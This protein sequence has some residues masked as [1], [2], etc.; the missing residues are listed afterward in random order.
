MLASLDLPETWTEHLATQPIPLRTP[1]TFR[2]V[3]GATYG[4]EGVLGASTVMWSGDV[5]G[6][7]PLNCTHVW[8]Y[9]QAGAALFPGLEASM[10]ATEFD[11]MLSPD[12]VLPHRVFMPPYLRQ[13]WDEP[14]GG[15]EE[16]AL[17][18][19]CGAVLKIYRELL[20]GA[21]DLSWVEARWDR[22]ASLMDHIARTWDPDDT[23]L[24]QGIQPTTHDI[25]LH[26]ANPFTGTYWLAALRAAEELA[27]L[28][29]DDA[30]A[31][32]WRARFERS[33]AGLDAECFRDGHYVQVPEP[34]RSRV[35]QR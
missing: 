13:L 14:I 2:S 17:G 9:A 30:R 7:C 32:R 20:R 19:M 5:G 28:L 22:I 1:T 18:G 16:P 12:G 33:S 6:S 34:G 27:R 3:D 31:E 24:L 8:N 26:G 35:H 29:G 10:R 15:P 25:G 23:G 11:V 4:F 21:V